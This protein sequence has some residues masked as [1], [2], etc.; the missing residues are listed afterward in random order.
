EEDKKKKEV[1]TLRNNLDTL[2]YQTEKMISDNKDK[3]SADITKPAE[4]AIVTAKAALETD[5]SA[6]LKTEYDKLTQASHQISAEVYK[7][8]SSGGGGDQGGSGGQTEEPSTEKKDGDDVID[9]D[10]KDVN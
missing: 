4:E 6:L 1:V 5:D 3:V 9:A 10:Y 2:I 8:T 7:A